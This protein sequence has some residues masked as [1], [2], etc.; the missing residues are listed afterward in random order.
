MSAIFEDRPARKL[1]AAELIVARI[2]RNLALRRFQ[3]AA[4]EAIEWRARKCLK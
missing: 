1:L 3:K 2:E 4:I